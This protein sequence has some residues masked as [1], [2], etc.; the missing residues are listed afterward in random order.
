MNEWTVGEYRSV[1]KHLVDALPDRR[2]QLLVACDPPNRRWTP[3]ADTTGALPWPALV[4]AYNWRDRNHQE[5]EKEL[6]PLFQMGQRFSSSLL[7]G[8]H[9]DA[10]N[11]DGQAFAAEVFEWGGINRHPAAGQF[12][13]VLQA[14]LAAAGVAP[15][16]AGQAEWSSGWTKVAAVCTRQFDDGKSPFTPQVIWDSRVANAIRLLIDDRREQ[17]TPRAVQQLQSSLRLIKGRGGCR[18]GMQLI[19]GWQWAWTLRQKWQAEASASRLVAAMRDQ[20]NKYPERYGKMPLG[21]GNRGAWTSW[22]VGL[23]LFVEGY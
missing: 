16:P 9:A 19:G 12:H 22:G 10:L 14:S 18:T 15:A 6:A 20:L 17:L 5:T 7:A 2:R 3:L 13:A 11:E 21:N 23:A 1:G 4:L 8:D